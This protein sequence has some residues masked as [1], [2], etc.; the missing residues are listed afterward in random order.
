MTES[1]LALL[2]PHELEAVTEIVP[3]GFE[4][5]VTVIEVPELTVMVPEETFQ[6]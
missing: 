2:V 3:P 4:L 6:L 5:K 1:E